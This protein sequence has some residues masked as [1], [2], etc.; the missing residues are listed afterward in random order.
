MV[1]GPA[2]SLTEMSNRMSPGG[3]GDRCVGFTLFPPS[4]ADCLKIMGVSTSG[5]RRVSVGLYMDSTAR[6]ENCNWTGAPGV[7]ITLL[8]VTESN[9]KHM[10]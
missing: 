10:R 9:V 6:N 5:A 1:L 4:C 2:L 7:S 3:K 8:S